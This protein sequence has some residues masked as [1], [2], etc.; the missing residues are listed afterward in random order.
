[1]LVRKCQYWVR[2]G[3]FRPRFLITSVITCGVADRPASSRATTS[4]GR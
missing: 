4:T 3:W 1:M 2:I